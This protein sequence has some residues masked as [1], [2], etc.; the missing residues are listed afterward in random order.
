MREHNISKKELLFHLYSRRQVGLSFRC[1]S[2][3][4][5]LGKLKQVNVWTFLPLLK[6]FM[7]I[8]CLNKTFP[9]LDEV[10]I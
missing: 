9:E 2:A 7:Y 10:Y 5:S 6:T 8:L 1:V 4:P 3:Q